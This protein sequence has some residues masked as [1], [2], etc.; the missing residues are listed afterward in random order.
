[1]EQYTNNR[2]ECC[3]Q[4]DSPEKRENS[5]CRLACVFG[6][7]FLFA[8]V[9]LTVMGWMDGTHITKYVFL[10][11]LINTVHLAAIL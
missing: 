8:G 4:F 10:S 7:I 5:F 11:K 6:F 9:S 1:M 2:T 3:E